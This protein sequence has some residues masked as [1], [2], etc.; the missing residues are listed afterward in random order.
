M[1]NIRSLG[2]ILMGIAIRSQGCMVSFAMGNLFFF[3][4]LGRP[5]EMA[6]WGLAASRII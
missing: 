3:E 4:I 5:M 2:P 6:V 1:G